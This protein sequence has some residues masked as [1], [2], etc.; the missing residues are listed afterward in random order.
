VSDPTLSA[1]SVGGSLGTVVSDV[2][3]GVSTGGPI[4]LV[5]TVFGLLGGLAFVL[6]SVVAD[7]LSSTPRRVSARVAFVLLGCS[8]LALVGLGVFQSELIQYQNTQVGLL[9]QYNRQLPLF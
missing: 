8:A 9:G 1:C 7:W 4:F 3:A 5:A 2:E 6:R